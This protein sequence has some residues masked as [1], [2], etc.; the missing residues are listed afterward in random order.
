[1]LNRYEQLFGEPVP[2]SNVYV[3]LK[4]DD[5]PDFDYYPFGDAKRTTYSFR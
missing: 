3:T 4:P 5:H 2:N 1:M